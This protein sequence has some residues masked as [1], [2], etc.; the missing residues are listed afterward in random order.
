MSKIGLRIKKSRSMMM[1]LYS[2][3]GLTFALALSFVVAMWIQVLRYLPGTLWSHWLDL[4]YQSFLL[5]TQSLVYSFP[6]ASSLTYLA[7]VGST[8]KWASLLQEFL[9]RIEQSPT[10]LYGFIFLTAFGE[11]S[12]SFVMGLSFLGV[13]RLLSRWTKLSSQVTVMELE[14]MLALGVSRLQIVY[15]LYAKRYFNLY[16]GHLF[17]VVCELF[18]LVTAFLCFF[19]EFSSQYISL[20]LFADYS[21]E[22]PQVAALALTL[23]CLHT[24]RFVLDRKTSYWEV[25]FG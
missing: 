2:L 25:E 18:G 21:L 5:I 12:F 23:L 4:F 8:S 16:L 13:A 17:A 10:L 7:V 3:S 1:S 14:S 22:T 20:K 19:P 9:H 24:L 15:H 11:N 6:V